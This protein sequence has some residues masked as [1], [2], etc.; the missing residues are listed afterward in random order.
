MG[1][2]TETCG[3]TFDHPLFLA[4]NF[5]GGP[6]MDSVMTAVSGWVMW[7]PLYAAILGF[8]WYKHG[9]KTCVAF[10]ACLFVA[11]GLADMLCGIF[12]HSGLLKNLWESFPPRWRPMFDP[13]LAGKGVHVVSDHH[14]FYGTVS[15][16]AATVAAMAL[17]SALVIR[18][19]WFTAAI[20]AVL[21]LVCYSRIYL[22]C[23]YPMDLALGIVLG[24]AA[25]AA[26][27]ALYKK[28]TS[29]IAKYAQ[30]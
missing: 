14:G 26:M 8:V 20:V 27:F 10:T 5:D 22:A 1:A 30:K 16:H 18:R 3:Y 4:L 11:M 13:A 2:M 21:L 15:S 17:M 29:Q 7:L 23:H 24:L 6:A 19:R 25:G 9:W 28:M 12:K